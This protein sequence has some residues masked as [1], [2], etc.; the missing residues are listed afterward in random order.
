MS[1]F[2]RPSRTQSGGFSIWILGALILGIVVGIVLRFISPAIL[3][4]TAIIGQIFGGLLLI[5]AVPLLTSQ[6][7]L[8]LNNPRDRIRRGVSHSR[9]LVQI[10][11]ATLILLILAAVVSAVFGQSDSAGP[12]AGFFQML[13]P[14]S[15]VT[16]QSG[17]AGLLVFGL[18]MIFAAILGVMGD[19]AQHLV[20]ICGRVFRAS[21]RTFRLLLWL[22]PLGL[23]SIVGVFGLTSVENSAPAAIP[24]PVVAVVALAGLFAYTTIV[25]G[26]EWI[27]GQL[28]PKRAENRSFD[29]DRRPGQRPMTGRYQSAGR[30]AGS[31]SRPT[32]RP[33]PEPRRDRE[34]SPFE[35]GVSSTPVLDIEAR[36]STQSTPSPAT[37][38]DMSPKPEMKPRPTR[39]NQNEA[40]RPA[41]ADRDRDS[42]PDSRRYPPRD[43]GP[44]PER[45]EGGRDRQFDRGPRE[46]RTDRPPRDRGPRP[47]RFDRRDT[48]R[49]A[50]PA[51]ASDTDFK[52]QP[53]VNSANM[54]DDL[55]RVRQQLNR[56]VEPES[57]KQTVTTPPPPP[58]PPAEKPP[59]RAAA[60]SVQ[61]VTPADNEMHYGR[62]RH[63]KGERPESEPHP[64][65]EP[66]PMPEMVDHY[67]TDDMAFGRGKRKKI[68][69]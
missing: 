23:A 14:I 56:E 2:S 48:P 32:G 61:V 10:L 25:L 20:T 55:A 26:V 29:R 19:R 28:R 52:P 66:P 16:F 30:T 62:S 37:R 17:G 4:Q 57:L 5:V 39:E 49:P 68:V 3:V 65:V 45:R 60:S 38:S 67:S 59:E 36:R 27:V 11:I 33:A 21:M 13:N 7:A 31:T 50:E 64:G 1:D 40:E 43:R 18:A 58:P 51:I 34:R 35:M 44:R 47:S 41:P 9:I 63:R 54:A 69:K 22:A 8:A 24:F 46:G 15:L 6:L 42:Q 53:V 12:V